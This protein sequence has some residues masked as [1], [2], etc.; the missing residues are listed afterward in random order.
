MDEIFHE[1]PDIPFRVVLDALL[2]RESAF[3]ARFLNRLSDL[4]EDELNQ[5]SHVWY[6]I[7]ELRRQALMEDVEELGPRDTMLS[8]EALGRFALADSDPMVRLLAVQILWEYESMDLIETFLEL[9]EKDQDALV[10]AAAATGL[11]RFVLA[12]ELDNHSKE[13]QSRIEDRLNQVIENAETPLESQR[14]LESLAYSS[15]LSVVTLIEQAYNSNDEE[16][17]VCSLHAMGVSANERWKNHIMSMLENISPRIRSAAVRAAGDLEI[18]DAVP[19]L[20]QLLD[21][22]DERVR[23][24]CI[25]ALSQT[26]GE[27]VRERLEQL[28]EYADGEEEQVLEEALENLEFIEGIPLMSFMEIP[29]DENTP[30]QYYDEEEWD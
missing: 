5:L 19:F 17:I 29:E 2:D 12:G 13:V 27:G 21:D 11:G 3:D 4:E 24:N 25:W 20:L 16:W 22:P 26:G 1:D 30:L 10:R 8:F 15:R 9:V 6:E 14:A 23:L 7:P 18:M 28:W